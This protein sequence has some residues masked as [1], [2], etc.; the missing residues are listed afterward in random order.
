ML[1]FLAAKQNNTDRRYKMHDMVAG[2][3]IIFIKQ[4]AA[5]TARCCR[6]FHL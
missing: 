5:S 6:V 1:L 4:Q 2:S 3:F